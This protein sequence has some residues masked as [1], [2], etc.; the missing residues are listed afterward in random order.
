MTEEELANLPL[1]EG[2]ED[3]FYAKGEFEEAVLSD[4]NE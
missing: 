4:F 2:P 3:A 1:A